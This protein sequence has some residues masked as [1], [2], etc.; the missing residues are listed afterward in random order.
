ML[1]GVAALLAPHLARP[2]FKAGGAT[3]LFLLVVF[4]PLIETLMMAAALE[5]LRL[6]L[7][8]TLAVLAS[9]IGWAIAHSVAAPMWGLVIWWPFLVFSTL[10]LAWRARGRARA[11]GIVFATHA[12]HNLPVALLLLRHS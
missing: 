5:L 3:L 12:L 6:A 4:S 10:Y 8:P 2:E 11:V 7:P 1:A 9:A